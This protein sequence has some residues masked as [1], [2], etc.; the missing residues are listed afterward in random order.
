[1][2]TL[3]DQAARLGACKEAL[4]Y[5]GD[6]TLQE[7]WRFC[8]FAV[9]QAWLIDRGQFSI[10]GIPGDKPVVLGARL[11]AGSVLSVVDRLDLK[12][13]CI[14]ILASVE[15]DQ[16]TAMIHD[17]LTARDYLKQVQKL[18]KTDH[19]VR[20]CF[21]QLLKTFEER[22]WLPVDPENPPSA[23]TEMI[24]YAV[25]AF[26]SSHGHDYMTASC[27]ISRRIRELFPL[28][29]NPKEVVQWPA[30]S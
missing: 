11:I 29:L 25:E 6:A 9:W 12:Q 21:Q 24:E 23:F 4:L 13:T 17:R 5:I 22:R 28:H 10:D 30:L 7:F 26:A 20:R 2:P 1:M 18:S 27:L 16:T 3:R 15:W 19:N 8:P 14:E